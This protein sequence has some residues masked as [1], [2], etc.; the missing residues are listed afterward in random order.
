MKTITTTA[1]AAAIVPVIH[2]FE[3]DDSSINRF[4]IFSFIKIVLTLSC[5]HNTLSVGCDTVLTTFDD[6]LLTMCVGV[7]VC[8]CVCTCML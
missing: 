8:V 6:V 1:A 7:G 2:V 4:F 5:V 3:L